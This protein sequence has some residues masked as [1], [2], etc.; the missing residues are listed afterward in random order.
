VV[1]PVE[2]SSL[3]LRPATPAELPAV[4]SLVYQHLP[5]VERVARCAHAF[6]LLEQGD[7]VLEGIWTAHGEGGL[8]GVLVCVPLVG[9]SALVWPPQ[10][11]AGADERVPDRLAAAGMAW[12]RSQKIKLAQAMPT[13]VELSRAQALTRHGFAHVTTLMYM[14]RG[15]ADLPA[16]GA[17]VTPPLTIQSYGEARACFKSTLLRTYEATQDCPELN[18]VRTIEEIIAAHQSQGQPDPARWWLVSEGGE[19]AGVVI[20]NDVPEWE[21]WDLTYLGVVPGS[22]GRGLGRALTLRAL[23]A[24]S[25]AG[26]KKLTLA[27]DARNEAARHLYTRLGFE[28]FDRREVFLAILEQSATAAAVS[29]SDCQ[30]GPGTAGPGDTTGSSR[31]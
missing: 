10:L 12:L 29:D 9:A 13:A 8:L 16:A 14:Q 11:S 18:G 3:Q 1:K 30:P 7:I 22:R 2:T 4:L 25:A 27:V 24:A 21:A 5:E 20:M 19:P 6:H 26:V 15:L 31:G 23:E 28:E 17:L